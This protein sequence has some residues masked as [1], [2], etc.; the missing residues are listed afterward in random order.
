MT[1]RKNP[2]DSWLDKMADHV[3]QHGL[4]AA[5]LRPLAKAAGTS[6]RML[7]Y[8]FVD[9]TGLITDILQRIAARLIQLMAERG[10]Q[11]PLPYAACLQRTVSILS[12]D[13]FAPYL[14]LFLSIAS[15]SALGNPLYRALGEQL[16]RAYFEWAKTQVARSTDTQHA[17]EAAKLLQ[18][19]EGMIFLRAIGLDD[20]NQLA[21][22]SQ[23]Q[24]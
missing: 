17:H 5:S 21:F 23:K 19:A 7:I 14:R 16:G 3:L 4:E 18:R 10:A 9:K 6:D 15:L 20:I 24:Q 1:K 8:Y 11:E 22:A 12:A 13:I 2:K